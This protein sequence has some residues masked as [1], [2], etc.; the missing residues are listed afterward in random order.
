MK[1]E[2]LEWRVWVQF[3]GFE[4]QFLAHAL[5][6]QVKFCMMDARRM[7]LT[8]TIAEEVNMTVTPQQG[9][10]LNS[11]QT[12]IDSRPS[13]FKQNIQQISNLQLK[14]IDENLNEFYFFRK[15]GNEK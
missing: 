11:L 7:E 4:I 14:K 9:D 1:W 2:F 6:K 12:R 5:P 15:K 8:Q 3:L 13:N 10:W